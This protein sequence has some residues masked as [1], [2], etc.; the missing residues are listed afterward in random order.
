MGYIKDTHLQKTTRKKAVHDLVHDKSPHN[1]SACWRLCLPQQMLI[2]GHP[3]LRGSSSNP[4]WS[5][6]ATLVSKHRQ[7]LVSTIRLLQGVVMPRQ[8]GRHLSAGSRLLYVV[9]RSVRG[10]IWVLCQ[11]CAGGMKWLLGPSEFPVH[12]K[13]ETHLVLGRWGYEGKREERFKKGT[14]SDTVK[15]SHNYQS[16]RTDETAG[17]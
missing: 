3:L 15:T 4:L 1:A 6:L 9:K 8:T 10:P 2:I 12:I 7:S 11:A 13:G 17:R 16:S 14:E 5:S